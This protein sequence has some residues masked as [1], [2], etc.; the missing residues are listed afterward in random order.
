[1]SNP[2]PNESEIYEKIKKENIT[3]HPLVWKLIEHHVYNDLYMINIILGATTLDGEP[4]TQED[5]KKAVG[6][7]TGIQ[8]F[9]KNLEKLT[10]QKT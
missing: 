4:L 2:L 6:H 8:N 9:L 1:M 7:S 10:R 5:A 3:V